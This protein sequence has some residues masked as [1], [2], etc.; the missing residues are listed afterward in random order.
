MLVTV[1]SQDSDVTHDGGGNYFCYECGRVSQTTKAWHNHRRLSHGA[2]PASKY[3]VDGHVCK[4]CFFCCPSISRLYQHLEHDSKEC[5]AAWESLDAKITHTQLQEVEQIRKAEAKHFTSLGY[6]ETKSLSCNVRAQGPLRTFSTPDFEVIDL[7]IPVFAPQ[8]ELT[9]DAPPGVPPPPAPLFVSQWSPSAPTAKPDGQIDPST[10]PSAT[11]F[12]LLQLPELNIKLVLHLFSGQ[13]RDHD[14]QAEFEHQLFQT[15]V[16]VSSV[17][18][19]S[20]DIVVHLQLG[21]LTNPQAI[22]AWQDLI[23]LGMVIFV[24]AGPPCETWSAARFLKRHDDGEHGPRP[25]RNQS[26]LW[27]LTCLRKAEAS[28]IAIGNALLRATIRMF[29][30]ALC[31]PTTAVIMEHPR[32]PEWMPL[33][34][35][36]WL[37]PELKYLAALP[38]CEAH[39]VDQCM[40]GAPSKKPTT[41]LC[42]QVKCTHLLH[43]A[44]TTCDN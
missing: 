9:F 32:R 24:M 23:L 2:F 30:A 25:L 15:G 16:C 41:L 38:N 5:L 12:P 10:L 42:L 37:L 7:T 43:E 36:S 29:F 3:L 33:A 1:S 40:H 22:A 6:R 19:L 21:D 44:A 35:S 27:G 31:S 20:L 14:L 11:C 34:P 26:Q 4:V 28:S 39:D 18:V 13:R 17:F 8:V